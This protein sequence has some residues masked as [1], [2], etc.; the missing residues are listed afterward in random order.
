Y[1][2]Q[3]GLAVQVHG[4]A[5]IL[6]NWGRGD[7]DGDEPRQSATFGPCLWG[8]FFLYHRAEHQG[9]RGAPFGHLQGSSAY[10][11]LPLRFPGGAGSSAE[12]SADRRRV[13]RG[14]NRPTEL[15]P[16]PGGRLCLGTRAGEPLG[17]AASALRRGGEDTDPLLRER[18]GRRCHCN[19]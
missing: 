4:H 18:W 11:G 10:A 12:L 1:L 9:A 8:Q 6:W 3:A 15:S 5:W 7:L 17:R 14:C 2:A 19:V 13:D 16:S